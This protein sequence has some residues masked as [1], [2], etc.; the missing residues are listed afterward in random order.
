VGGADIVVCGY[1]PGALDRFGLTEDELSERHP[2][3][4]IVYLDA[5]GHTGS[6]A[7]RRGFDSVVQAP[8]GIGMLQSSDGSTPGALPY[9]LLDHGT[10][11]LA[12]AA[13]LDGVRRQALEGGTHVRRVSLARTASWLTSLR[14]PQPNPAAPE[15]DPLPWTER[16]STTRQ[17]IR[18]VSPP[19][20]IDGVPLRWPRVGHY[21]ANDASWQ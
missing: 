11:Y 5:W 8:T 4:V 16:V 15:V 17:T 3:T 19:G 12:A 21:G 13:A 14:T 9:Q 7:H 2:G 6:W 18:S 20:Q 1:R 10:G